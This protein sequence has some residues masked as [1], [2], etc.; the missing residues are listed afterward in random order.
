VAG[1]TGSAERVGAG[2]ADARRC[3]APS[4][5]MAAL[6][7][8]K[9]MSANRASRNRAIPAGAAIP[10]GTLQAFHEKVGPE[11]KLADYANVRC[12]RQGGRLE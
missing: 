4:A 11:P 12:F 1:L 7:A 8:S 3:L 2:L 9:T 10:E 6:N 5:P